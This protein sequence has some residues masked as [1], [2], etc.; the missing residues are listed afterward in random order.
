MQPKE[1]FELTDG[2][3]ITFE[4]EVGTES[5]GVIARAVPE[6]GYA[7]AV[8]DHDGEKALEAGKIRV[9]DVHDDAEG[10]FPHANAKPGDRVVVADE[11]RAFNVLATLGYE[12][13]VPGP[14][15]VV[16]LSEDLALPR[17][18]VVILVA[19]DAP[20]VERVQA[21]AADA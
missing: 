12:P 8:L 17:D 21:E 6:Y 15:D 10:G 7:V 3:L 9:I 18:A 4:R 1:L 5:D 16:V 19:T 11:Q 13:R 20:R 14:T 2:D